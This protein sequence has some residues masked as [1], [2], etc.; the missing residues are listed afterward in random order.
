MRSLNKI[1]TAIFCGWLISGV[2]LV[3]CGSDD[4]NQDPNQDPQRSA[5][6]DPYLR[7]YYEA[8]AQVN[9]WGWRCVAIWRIP[10]TRLSDIDT[11]RV[12]RQW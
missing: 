10:V 11:Y 4:D 2:F 3:G 6:C 8:V 12:A 1:M 5:N 7:Q 9:D